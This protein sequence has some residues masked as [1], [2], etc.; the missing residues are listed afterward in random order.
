MRIRTIKPE[1]WTSE[2]VG[3]LSRDARLTF[4]GLWSLADDS[5]RL[6]GALPYLSGALF[7]Y[8]LDARDMVESWVVELERLGM[9]R[10]YSDDSGSRYID[11]PK[12]LAHQK[13]EKP[14][15]SRY[16][17]FTECSPTP[18]R[19]VVEGSPG[20]L[21]SRIKDLGSR[22]KDHGAPQAS[23][24]SA[25]AEEPN[26]DSDENLNPKKKKMPF[27][28]PSVDEV[29]AYCGERSN[30]IDAK[31]FVD[32]YTA[33]GWMIGKNRVKCW[34]ACVRTWE[35]MARDLSLIHI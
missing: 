11:I 8:D 4:I 25:G 31:R 30:G 20:D 16:P 35:G 18:P 9:I 6:R 15:R 17:A 27:R 3:T 23:P 12:W 5:G 2:S 10:R 22:I 34:K 32:H 24:F 19:I 26:L 28:P 14:S 7:P 29:T 13:I 33:K 1:F 21:G